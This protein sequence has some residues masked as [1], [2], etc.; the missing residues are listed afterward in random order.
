MGDNVKFFQ[1]NTLDSSATY[2]F[3]SATTADSFKLYDNNRSITLSSTGSNDVTPE[4]WEV[5][6]GTSKEVDSI[7]MDNHNVKSGNVKYWN[8]ASF[9]DFSPAISLSSNSSETNYF[10]VTQVSTEKIQITM[11]TT[12]VVDD[13][14]SMGQFRAI[15]LIGEPSINPTAILPDYAERS[16]EHKVSDNGSVK[17]DFGRKLSMDMLFEGNTDADIDMF[18]TLKD[19]RSSF[20]VYV[21]SGDTTLTQDPFRIQDMFQM[22]YINSFSPQL[23]GGLFGIGN[24]IRII[25]AQV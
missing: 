20:L 23:N 1:S 13:E 2:T 21:N 15:E 3:T 18:R 22:N 19:L 5:D 11:N 25:V 8:G 16:V 10:E 24:N 7:F 12:F 4:V 9:V 17:V 14:K 6:F